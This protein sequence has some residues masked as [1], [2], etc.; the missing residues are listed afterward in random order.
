VKEKVCEALAYAIVAVVC[1]AVF[2]FTLDMLL[3][4]A[5]LTVVMLS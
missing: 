5:G 2:Y 4:L 1:V 3:E